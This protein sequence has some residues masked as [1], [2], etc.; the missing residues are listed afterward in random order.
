M[1]RITRRV[2]VGL[3]ATCGALGI[4]V[5]PAT[6]ADYAPDEFTV[7]G[8]PN[9][10]TK[11][12]ITWYNRTANIQGYV[13]DIS[14]SGRSTTAVFEAFAG[15]TKI[16]SETRTANNESDLGAIRSFNF[17]IGDTDLVGGIDRIK[18]T[19]CQQ[20]PPSGDGCSSPENYSK[21]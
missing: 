2:A 13:L 6:A 19:V 12:A 14:G 4:G 10:H 5:A 18:V 20:P 8:E 16:D 7:L 21:D 1:F 17:T 15:S 9:G 3:L 11:G